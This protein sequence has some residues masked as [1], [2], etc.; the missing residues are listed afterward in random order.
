MKPA[1]CEVCGKEEATSFSFFSDHGNW[2]NGTWK[3]CGGCTSDQEDYYIEFDRFFKTRGATIDWL[4]HMHEKNWMN[5]SNFMDM[6]HRFRQAT[7][8]FREL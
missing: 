8:S 7:D 4:A 1:I 5:W 2:E 6:I 3:F